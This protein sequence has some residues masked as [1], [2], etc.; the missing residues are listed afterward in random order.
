MRQARLES[1]TR[2]NLWCLLDMLS[3]EQTFSSL[4]PEESL[5]FLCLCFLVMDLKIETQDWNFPHITNNLDIKMSRFYNL[6]N[7]NVVS[8][9]LIEAFQIK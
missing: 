8:L 3:E 7:K 1:Q 9:N 5:A 2:I 4:A 6:Y